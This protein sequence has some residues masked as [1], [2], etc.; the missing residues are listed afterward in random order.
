MF[1]YYIQTSLSAFVYGSHNIYMTF[2]TGIISAGDY[3]ISVYWRS[4]SDNPVAITTLTT[5]IEN[6]YHSPRK[7]YVL[8][9]CES[10]SFRKG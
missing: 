10:P 9:T 8:L 7:I 3:T 1:Y 5:E 6:Y 4:I 2:D